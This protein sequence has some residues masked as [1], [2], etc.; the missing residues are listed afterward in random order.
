MTR[1][2]VSVLMPCYRDHHLVERSVPRI[3]GSSK[4]ELEVVLINNDD[5][6]IEQMRE[7]VAALDD[8]RLR[9]LELEHEA[10][11]GKAI[12]AGLEATTGELAFFAN[13]DLFVSA[14]YLDEMEQFFER[15]PTAACATG[16][17]LRYDL[18]RDFE[19]NIIDTTGLII[20]RNR[21]VSDRGENQVDR[22]QYDIEEEVFGVSGA[23]LVARR[24]A[25]ESVQVHGECLDETFCMYKE[26]IDLAWRL[27]LA[28]CECWYVPSAVAYHGRASHGLAGRGY[29]SSIRAF[30]ENERAKP[31]YVRLNSMKNQWLILVKN[32]DLANVARDLPYIVGRET[33]VA[34]YNLA[35]APRN[36]VTALSEFFKTLPEARSKRREIKARQKT[37]SSQI[38]RW[39]D[40]EDRASRDGSSTSR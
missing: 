9:L 20:G 15:R 24:D 31:S 22:W 30:H 33:L 5:E 6:Q 25:L 12:N 13:S 11:F 3:L 37:T 40:G 14:G 29:L 17:I 21:R 4:R 38:R 26:D 8:S 32:D 1:P 35:F 27:R 23:A 2:M 10:G 16:K 19:T 34:G 36:T 39:F 18:D 28:G 7:L